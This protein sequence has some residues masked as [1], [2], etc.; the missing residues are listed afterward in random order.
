MQ[1][2]GTSYLHDLSLKNKQIVVAA[3]ANR[4][5]V[6]SDNPLRYLD[7]DMS[8]LSQSHIFTKL[9]KTKR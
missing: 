8:C 9:N 5:W 2:E 3:T 7:L 4:V 6:T 1:Y